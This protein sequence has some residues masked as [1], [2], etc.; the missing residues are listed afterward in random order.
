MIRRLLHDIGYVIAYVLFVGANTQ[1]SV[2]KRLRV[3]YRI[4]GVRIVE[5]PQVDS[6]ERTI[7]LCPYRN[8]AANWFGEKWICHD[9]LDRVDDG[10]VTYLRRHKGIDYQRPR[11]CTDLAYCDESEY[12]YS[13][14]SEL[15]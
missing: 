12:C 14:V 4:V 9:I 6:V 1:E 8:L 3:A 5:T 7:F 13:E 10:Y 2:V 11:G 15:E